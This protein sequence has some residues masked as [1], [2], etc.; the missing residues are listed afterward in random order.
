VRTRAAWTCACV[1][2]LRVRALTQFPPT[3]A[4]TPGE[5]FEYTHLA[6][7]LKA[8]LEADP[9]CLD[10]ERLKAC[11][12]PALRALLG[13]PRAL[14][15]E[16]ERARL[17]RQTAAIL[18]AQ[19][20]GSAATLIGMARGSA[21]VLVSLIAAHFPA[22]R[23]H[24]QYRGRQVFFYKRA[25]I[26]VGDLHGAFG[27]DGLGSFADIGSLTMFADY[28]VPVVLRQLG[29]LRYTPA[30]AALLDAHTELPAGCEQECEIRGC[31]I[32]AVEA[33][34]TA[35]C[36]AASRRNEAGPTSVTL[37][38]ALWEIGEAARLTSPAHHRTLGVF[39]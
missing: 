38:W 9:H 7:G 5:A 35:L 24:A 31:S 26:F 21:S 32:A 22:F 20:E 17:L 30:L 27:G 3:A 8:A 13:W 19:F 10:C 23:D 1:T 6:G 28:R 4:P 25:Q 2:L 15:C 33:L 14:P 36:M 12:G 37:D 18:G 16:E 34:R 29:M 11:D 39:Y